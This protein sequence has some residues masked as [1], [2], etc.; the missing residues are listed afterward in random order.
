M[1]DDGIGM[2]YKAKRKI[3]TPLTIVRPV[4]DREKYQFEDAPGI[5]Y[6]KSDSFEPILPD[7]WTYDV[8]V[9]NNDKKDEAA[10]QK[11]C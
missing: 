5:R 10:G 3:K 6:L 1:S 9:M 7:F 4:I 11:D 2:F 8:S